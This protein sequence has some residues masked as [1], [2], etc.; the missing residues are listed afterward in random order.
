MFLYLFRHPSGRKDH[1]IS[2]D[3]D[4]RTPLLRWLHNWR[5]AEPETIAGIELT[6]TGRWEGPDVAERPS[7]LGL[8]RPRDGWIHLA[9]LHAPERGR[10]SGGGGRRRANDCSVWPGIVIDGWV[11][12]VV[13]GVGWA[14]SAVLLSERKPTPLRRS[15]DSVPYAANRSCRIHEPASRLSVSITVCHARQDPGS[16]Q[17]Q[18]GGHNQTPHARRIARLSNRSR[19]G[20]IWGESFPHVSGSGSGGRNETA[21]RGR[22]RDAAERP[23]TDSSSVGRRFESCPP[24]QCATP[25]SYVSRFGQSCPIDRGCQRSPH[26]GLLKA[27]AIVFKAM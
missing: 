21:G 25:R 14:K 10:G 26:R 20:R 1:Q 16:H 9:D 23:S 18:E 6:R 4:A 7:R 27:A 15:I 8:A 2:V 12:K 19:W 5:R 17:I 13:T 24:H 3:A 11:V 22:C